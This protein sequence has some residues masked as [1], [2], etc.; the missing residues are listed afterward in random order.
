MLLPGSH[1]SEGV[2]S[3]EDDYVKEREVLLDYPDHD[4]E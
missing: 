1:V 3:T 4:D 2:R